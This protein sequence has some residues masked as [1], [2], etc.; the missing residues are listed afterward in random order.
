[1]R[2]VPRFRY[3]LT[4]VVDAPAA[5]EV[6]DIIL[7]TIADRAI[8]RISTHLYTREEGD[9][10]MEFVLVSPAQEVSALEG[11]F[12]DLM[13]LSALRDLTWRS[14]METT[15]QRLLRHRKGGQLLNVHTEGTR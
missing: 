4:A 15:R 9:V 6:Q 7:A 8:E 10:A 5:G 12:P 3:W 2:N 11:L 1:M 14:E 13:R